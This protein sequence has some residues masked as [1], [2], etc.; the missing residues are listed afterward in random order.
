MEKL[1][2]QNEIIE[3]NEV[4]VTQLRSENK[5]LKEKE[6]YV[7]DELAEAQTVNSQL[8]AL[9]SELTS[10]EKHYELHH[11]DTRELLEVKRSLTEHKETISHL[12]ENRI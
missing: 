4:E 5:R 11:S 10:K 1:K 7:E 3:C 9:L 12:V 8:R 2:I 6:A